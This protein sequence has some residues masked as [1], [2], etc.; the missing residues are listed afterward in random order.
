M[1]LEIGPSDEI[2]EVLYKITL[3]VIK[4][5]GIYISLLN[6]ALNLKRL[7]ELNISHIFVAGPDSFWNFLLSPFSNVIGYTFCITKSES[8]ESF[9]ENLPILIDTIDVLQLSSNTLK[10]VLIHG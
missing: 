5:K 6:G 4:D 7:K 10:N 8:L 2:I 1:V 9:E 3:S